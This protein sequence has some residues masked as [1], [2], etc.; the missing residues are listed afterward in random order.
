MI[1]E[2]KKKEGIL[3]L[4]KAIKEY[5][6]N[7]EIS[8]STSEIAMAGKQIIDMYRNNGKGDATNIMKNL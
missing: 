8:L 4:S 7:P 3:D 2:E 6:T 5:A 1:T